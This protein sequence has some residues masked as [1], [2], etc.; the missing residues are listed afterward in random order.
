MREVFAAAGW[1]SINACRR[2]KQNSRSEYVFC[3]DN[4]TENIQH[5]Y[6]KTMRIR[7]I[8]HKNCYIFILSV[9]LLCKGTSMKVTNINL[10]FEKSKQAVVCNQ[11]WE[12][13]ETSS[14]WTVQSNIYIIL[15][16][17]EII[18]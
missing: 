8:I 14:S 10:M 4:C 12:N 5:I 11:Q 16:Y 7:N 1:L 18:Q 17:F 13:S 9:G 15:K 6:R 2:I 3:K